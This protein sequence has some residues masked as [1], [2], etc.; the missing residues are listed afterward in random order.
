MNQ[1]CLSLLNQI[2]LNPK[3]LDKLCFLLIKP[4]NE[5][6]LNNL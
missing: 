3:I 4:H 6:F 2:F 5:I 1:R